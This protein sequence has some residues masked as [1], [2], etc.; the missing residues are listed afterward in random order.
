MITGFFLAIFYS[1]LSFFIVLLPMS[2]FPAEIT[3]AFATIGGYINALSF[4]LP[5]NTLLTVLGLA[6]IF[7][8]TILLWRLSHLIARYL[9]GR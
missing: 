2:T 8:V 7:H 6:M 5:I 4:L 9:R 3:T 1:F